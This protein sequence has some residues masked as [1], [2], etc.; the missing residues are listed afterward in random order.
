MDLPLTELGR[1]SFLIRMSSRKEPPEDS[2]TSLYK[3]SLFF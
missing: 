1:R 3:K 2:L